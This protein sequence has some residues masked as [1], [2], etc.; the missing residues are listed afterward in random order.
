[1]P[2]PFLPDNLRWTDAG[3][4][5]VVGQT[6]DPHSLFSCQEKKLPC[7]MGYVVAEVDPASLSIV[8]LLTGTDET[9]AASGFGSGTGAIQV[10]DAL[11]IGTFFGDRV[12]RFPM[13]KR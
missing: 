7:P 6:S 4:L 12:A 13:P 2:T 10:G 1:M 8:A 11:W 5:L 3:K 9:Y